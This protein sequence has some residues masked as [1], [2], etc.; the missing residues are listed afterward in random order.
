V[1]LPHQVVDTFASELQSL[2]N[3][4]QVREKKREWLAWV[5]LQFQSLSSL[6]PAEKRRI[7]QELNHVKNEIERLATERL[8]E[9][10]VTNRRDGQDLHPE[11]PAPTMRL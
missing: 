10:D 6:E 3:A 4:D 9:L 2:A 8:L 1:S 11:L 5:R 7:G